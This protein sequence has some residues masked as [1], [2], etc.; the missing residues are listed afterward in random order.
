MLKDCVMLD[1]H[2]RVKQRVVKFCG[3]R[4]LV[5][6][7]LIEA[8]F[9]LLA[10]RLALRVIPFRWLTPCFERPA[11]RP[12]ATYAR[13]A[14]I[15]K[16]SSPKLYTPHK[17]TISDDERKRLREGMQW[18]INE[19]AWFLPGETACFARAIAAQSIL[20]RLGIGTT[21]FYGAA[22]LP[23]SGLT[24]HVW[25]QD[26]AVGIIGHDTAQR[27]HVLARYPDKKNKRLV[28]D[29]QTAY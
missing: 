2:K 1:W 21:L 15:W 4:P 8:V 10:A 24:A 20:R 14:R 16:S 23:E 12:E 19:A 13:R 27:Y 18:L 7:Y 25:L 9:C 26:G 28:T 22:T 3:L 29:D 6:R 17:D 11:E 5:R